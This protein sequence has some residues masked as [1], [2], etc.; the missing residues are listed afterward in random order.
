MYKTEVKICTVSVDDWLEKYCF[1]EKFLSACVACPDYNRV[2]SCPPCVPSSDDYIKPYKTAYIIGVKVIYSPETRT[3]ANTPA[4]TEEL[5]AATYGNVKHTLLETLLCMER[6]FGNCITIA[7]GRCE[8]CSECTRRS[9]LPCRTPEK[10]RYS[11][12][13]FGFDLTK[14]SEALLE[15][16][17]LWSPQGL[18]EYNM[19]IAALL[20]K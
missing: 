2:W 13:A 4:L 16:K 1:P 20:T 5:R 7:A 17:L 11:F 14:I 9:G 18:P 19:A 3:K 8:L 12:S 10:L 15:T 6:E